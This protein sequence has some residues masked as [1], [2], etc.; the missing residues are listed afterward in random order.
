[1]ECYNLTLVGYTPYDNP[2]SIFMRSSS[3]L[4]DDKNGINS[5]IGRKY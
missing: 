4:H 2:S 5:I 1:M 3:M